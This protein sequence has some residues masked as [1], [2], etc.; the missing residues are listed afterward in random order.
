MPD[1][2]LQRLSQRLAERQAGDLERIEQATQRALAKHEQILSELSS[3]ARDGMQHDTELLRQSIRATTQ[4]MVEARIELEKATSAQ[5]AEYTQAMRTQVGKYSYALQKQQKA[6]TAS[7]SRLMA[8]S[9]VS[10]GLIWGIALAGVLAALAA[11]V[12]A[13]M[14]WR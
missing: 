5:V 2:S 14:A 12:W 10:L 8:R 4:A 6:S 7:L 13:W 3:A 11:W 9:V 1:H